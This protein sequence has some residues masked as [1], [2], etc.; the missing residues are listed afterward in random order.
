MQEALSISAE[1]KSNYVV[2]FKDNQWVTDVKHDYYHQMQGCMHLTNRS[3]CYLVV[4]TPNDCLVFPI[5]KDPEWS[6]NISRL[7]E[8]F[9]STLVPYLLDNI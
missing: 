4:W 7:V 9:F 2:N 1:M 6:P 3:L 8:F 5:H